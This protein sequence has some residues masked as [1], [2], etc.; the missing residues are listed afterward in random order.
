MFTEELEEKDHVAAA[1]AVRWFDMASKELRCDGLLFQLHARQSNI[2]QNVLEFD[3]SKA[4][5]NA[6]F[7]N[8][9]GPRL[10]KIEVDLLFCTPYIFTLESTGSRDISSSM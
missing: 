5:L 7:A 2:L 1:F 6:L 4:F 8:R 3:V 10:I 9:Q